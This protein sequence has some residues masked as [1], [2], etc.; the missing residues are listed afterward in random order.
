LAK[1]DNQRLYT[2]LDAITD[3]IIIIRPDK[4]IEYMN[5]TMTKIFGPA[6]NRRCYQVLHCCS[7]PCS[8]CQAD[9]I[10]LKGQSFFRE[11]YIEHL[12]K[13]FDIREFPIDKSD[14]TVSI[15]GR[16]QDIS[17]AKLDEK[18]LL[19][20]Q[21]DYRSLFEHAACGVFISSKEGKFEDV[22]K[23]MMNMLGYDEKS[24]LLK[25]DI[26]QDV[27]Y[28]AEDRQHF[29]EMIERDGKVI[30]YEVYF[31]HKDGHAVPVMLTGHVRYGE[32]GEIIG[33]E[34]LNVDQTQ[35][36]QMES[37]L[38]KTRN[39]L[40][41]SEKM[42]SLGKLSA[43]VAHQLNN[44]LSGITL[45]SQL[46]M[47]DYDL[48][49]AAK[50]DFKRVI[51]NVNRCSEIVKQLLQFTRK[52]SQQIEPNDINHT[53]QKTISMLEKQILF[54]N[55]EIAYQLSPDL[56]QIMVDTQQIIHVFMNII[57][58]AADAMDGNGTLTLESWHQKKEDRIIVQIS[59]TG[60]GIEPEIINNIFDPF[61]TTKPEGK[62]TGLGLS[63]AYG[64][65]ENH[66][67]NISA[68]SKVN[69]GTTFIIQLPVTPQKDTNNGISEF[70]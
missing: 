54:Q 68:K 47:E 29:R 9:S 48:S 57:I 27:Y 62:G 34:G 25:K 2:I 52:T 44:P 43:G 21:K 64:I 36:K 61:F 58:N 3:G 33:Y 59:D 63:M 5:I 17:K 26:A 66:G 49:E 53:I 18:K 55:I 38:E 51:A 12:D 41:Q 24:E 42:A 39:Q 19:A 14:G 8:K 16:Y 32:N 45:Y 70:I 69:E 23:T 4:S 22:N 56:P 67:G 30:D 46:I 31:K 35:K 40:L 20:S 1:K 13:S 11:S 6:N 60:P 37:E 28:N 50:T 15:F 7:E 65:I 10:I